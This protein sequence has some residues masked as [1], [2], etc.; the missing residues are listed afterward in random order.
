MST[1]KLED[2]EAISVQY[3]EPIAKLAETLKLPLLHPENPGNV[4]KTIAEG[5]EIYDLTI[6]DELRVALLE[7]AKALATV[8]SEGRAQIE[9]IMARIYNAADSTDI[10]LQFEAIQ[11]AKQSELLYKPETAERFHSL[12][13]KAQAAFSN[14][15][16]FKTALKIAEDL[17]KDETSYEFHCYPAGRLQFGA[18]P[19]DETEL[20]DVDRR[21]LY[22]YQKA[23]TRLSEPVVFVHR[24]V[25]EKKW[26]I[27]NGEITK[28]Y[29]SLI[30]CWEITHNG[31]H[32]ISRI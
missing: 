23:S 20:I 11:N 18:K 30:P 26:E 19:L 6:P 10:A 13:K 17:A 7:R 1:D 4:A 8:I 32:G 28:S 5:A 24:I 27:A 16:D 3:A 14:C 15:P 2:K 21:T 12:I 9:A 29:I 31:I 25:Y 22:Q